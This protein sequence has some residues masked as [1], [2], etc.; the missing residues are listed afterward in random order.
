MLPSYSK[1]RIFLK[2]PRQCRIRNIYTQSNQVCMLYCPHIFV[3]VRTCAWIL[4][5]GAFWRQTL[6]KFLSNF[7]SGLEKVTTGGGGG[8]S[9]LK[10][11]VSWGHTKT[12]RFPP[13]RWQEE[14][15]I[16]RGEEQLPLILTFQ[17]YLIMGRFD[18][19]WLRVPFFICSMRAS[20]RQHAPI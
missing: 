6:N 7:D 11:Q 20:Q 10:V 12:G 3:C 2:A 4:T 5:N 14:R 15:K 18:F 19:L 8:A 9:P 17:K 1:L 16:E 13:L